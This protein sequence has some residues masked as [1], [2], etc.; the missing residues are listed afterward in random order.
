MEDFENKDKNYT[1]ILLE[2]KNRINKINEKISKI[3]SYG[4]NTND[5]K[6]KLL[7]LQKSVNEIASTNEIS[8]V[9][10]NLTFKNISSLESETE[11]I[12]KY[13]SIFKDI[14]LIKKELNDDISTFKLEQI[15]YIIENDLGYFN[16]LKSLGYT[17]EKE[18]DAYKTI[19]EIIKTE[20]RKEGTSSLLKS[21]LSNYHYIFNDL[22]ELVNQD[23]EKYIKNPDIYKRFNEILAFNNIDEKMIYLLSFNEN[24]YKENLFNELN[25][26]KNNYLKNLENCYGNYYYDQNNELTITKYEIIPHQF[27]QEVKI[28]IDYKNYC[29][30]NYILSDTWLDEQK[31][32]P[33]LMDLN[34]SINNFN[35]LL[36]KIT[37]RQKNTAGINSAVPK[38]VL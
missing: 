27:Y 4:Y 35:N 20:F 23:I 10:I 28:N 9:I 37:H 19:Y 21:I 15:I 8:D 33:R 30:E 25:E 12:N 32:V 31:T 16:N 22:L 2:M 5:L 17:Y 26:T 7:D 29:S 38:E 14:D 3:E 36:D 6:N 18:K 1:K 34:I 24:N 13:F 11:K